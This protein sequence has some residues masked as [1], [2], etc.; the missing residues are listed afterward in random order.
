M[1][2]VLYQNVAM[3]E[4]KQAN[5][6]WLLELPDPIAKVTWDNFVMISPA[7][8]KQLFDLDLKNR[9]QSDEYEVH[10]EKQVISVKVGNR[11]LKL[12]A[13]VIPGMNNETI[14]IALGYGRQS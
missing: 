7:L 10:P 4:G 13:L 5:N 6:P 9:R 11:E 2:L 1:E 3:G 12:P 8:G 14:A